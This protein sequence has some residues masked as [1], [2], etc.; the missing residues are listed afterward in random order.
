MRIVGRRA[1]EIRTSRIGTVEIKCEG[2]TLKWWLFV[3]ACCER[4]RFSRLYQEILE[5]AKV[6]I[7]PG[8]N[9]E[10]AGPDAMHIA[11]ASVPRCDFLLTW[12]FRHIANIRIGFA[13]R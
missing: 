4:R 9:P 7:A 10:R 2:A 3:A 6:L 5:L 12:N 1:F 11:A 13:V 8:A